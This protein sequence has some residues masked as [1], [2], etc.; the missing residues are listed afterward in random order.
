MEITS[1]YALRTVAD[2]AFDL[3]RYGKLC[4]ALRGHNRVAA[5]NHWELTPQPPAIY[6][7]CVG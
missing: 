7:E 3:C 2:E 1:E 5:D 6:V 4:S